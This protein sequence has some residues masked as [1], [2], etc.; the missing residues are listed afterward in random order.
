M[1]ILTCKRCKK[2]W[3][4]KGKSTWQAGCPQCGIKVR[5]PREQFSGEFDENYKEESLY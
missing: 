5:L 3:D 4:Y 2:V 1:V